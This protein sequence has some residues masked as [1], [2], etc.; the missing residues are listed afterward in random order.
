MEDIDAIK[1][2]IQ[3]NYPNITM[4]GD[5]DCYL[6][7][8]AKTSKTYI[9]FLKKLKNN[10]HAKEV[11]EYLTEFNLKSHKI[12]TDITKLNKFVELKDLWIRF[13]EYYPACKNP[14]EILISEWSW[15][16]DNKIEILIDIESYFGN[17]SCNI[18]FKDKEIMYIVKH[19]DLI[20][21]DNID[22]NLIKR[23]KTFSHIKFL[24]CHEDSSHYYY[25]KETHTHQHCLG[26]MDDRDD[27]TE[28]YEEEPDP[29]TLKFYEKHINDEPSEEEST[30]QVVPYDMINAIFRVPNH[31]FL[32]KEIDEVVYCCKKVVDG[33]EIELSDTDKTICGSLG[34]VFKIF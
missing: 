15:S 21:Q 3:N 32:V 10:L 12:F 28:Y 30:L 5:D 22:E 27:I 14:S 9:K 33:Q 25:S 7:T 17:N 23:T 16:H 13:L 34:I 31:G 2:Y 6:I 26:I 1:V 4:I 8:S 11:N 18:I 20:I 29:K 24:E 19:D